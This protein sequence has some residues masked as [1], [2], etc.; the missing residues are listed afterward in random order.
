MA[1]SP[2]ALSYATHTDVFS[3][4]GANPFEKTEEVL[5]K[6][7]RSDVTLPLVL[8]LGIDEKK[9]AGFTHGIYE[10][11]P[12]FAVDITPKGTVEKEAT[13]V[14]E[15]MKKRDMKFLEGRAILTLEAPEGENSK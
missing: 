3:L 1:S 7:Y 8:F 14:I 6:E 5:I 10:G 2:S 15:E 12:Y 11:T 9:K 13:G 4:V